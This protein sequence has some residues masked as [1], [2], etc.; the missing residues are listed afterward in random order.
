MDRRSLRS[1]R[2]RARTCAHAQSTASLPSI[3]RQREDARGVVVGARDDHAPVGADRQVLHA[4]VVA[5]PR[6]N[7]AARAKVPAARGAV[8]AARED[9][10]LR[11]VPAHARDAVQVVAA[12][13]LTQRRQVPHEQLAVD[14][15]GRGERQQAREADRLDG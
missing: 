13:A 14:P 5:A 1:K 9:E 12:A 10:W 3:L 6:A 11:R 2:T 8:E 7:R 4:G 15:G